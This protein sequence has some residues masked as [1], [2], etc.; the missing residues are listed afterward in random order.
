MYKNVL[1]SALLATTLFFTTLVLADPPS[2]NHGDQEWWA[3]EDTSQS[4]PPKRYPF[5]ECGVGE[6][7]SPVDLGVAKISEVSLNS[8]QINYGTD[9]VTF[10]NTGHGIQVDTSADYAGTMNIGQEAYPLIQ[11]HFHE[12][13]EH[14]LN[15]E[16]FP[17]ELHFVHVQED[18]KIAVLAA[19]MTLGNANADFQIILDNMPR[20]ANEKNFNSDLHVNLAAL[21]PQLNQP[22]QYYTLAG[23]LT[24]PP[25]SEGV[26]WYILPET[27]TIS[28][29][30]LDQLK[31]FYTNNARG[32][33]ELNGRSLLTPK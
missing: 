29:E 32:I 26:Q 16:R 24:T 5:A 10:F 15:G 33:Q 30:Q 17:A 28:S 25:C 20:D 11:L 3:L 12:P 6:H 19:A 2:W 31:S 21:L 8:M 23:S 1:R 22:I 18:G 4:Y 13:S 14:T 9:A 27:V 7:Q